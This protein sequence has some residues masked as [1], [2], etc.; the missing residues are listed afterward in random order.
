MVRNKRILLSLLEI[1]S[2]SLLILSCKSKSEINKIRS[3]EPGKNEKPVTSS[4][5]SALAWYNLED[6]NPQTVK[7]PGELNE[8]SGITM[9]S[10]GRL[11]CEVDEDA[12]IF[13]LDYKTGSINKKF[14]A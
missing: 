7:L 10:D 2:F 6:E 5:G 13:E 3:E 1:C 12:D 11:F 14:Y 4:P 9:T 8:I